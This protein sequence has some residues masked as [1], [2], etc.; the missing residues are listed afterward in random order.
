MCKSYR[1]NVAAVVLSQAYPKKKLFLLARRS[2][3]KDI[4]QFPQGGVD[5]GETHEQALF[6]ELKEEIGT[7]EL[8]LIAKMDKELKYDF[9]KEALRTFDGFKGQSQTYFLLRLKDDEL[10]SLDV[11]TPEFDAFEFICEDELFKRVRHFKKALYKKALE[12][13]KKEGYL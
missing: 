9:P 4:W 7:N 5:P 13:F 3:M 12:Y 8:E 1:K 6:R 2:D 11:K 10:L